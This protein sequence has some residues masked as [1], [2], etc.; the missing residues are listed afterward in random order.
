VET[1]VLGEISRLRQMTVAEL[2]R[3]WERVFGE[4]PTS[5]N[6]Q[7]LWRRLA[8]EI[9]AR[10]HGGLSPDAH[11]RL[12]DL[13]EDA[14]NRAT[15]RRQRVHEADPPAPPPKV[16]R[17]RDSRLPVPG[18]ILTRDYHG[19]EIRVVALDDGQFEYD[20]KVYSSLSAV[21]RAVT[22]QKWN[23]RLFF[24]LTKRKR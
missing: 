9:Q 19:V 22:G 10:A 6:R 24:G 2:R 4:P 23:G 1:N 17:I 11:A 20:G 21:A 15:S 5:Q 18:T 14:W 7:H 16:T 13:G 3:E 8:W 12:D